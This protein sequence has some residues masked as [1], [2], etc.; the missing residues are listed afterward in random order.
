MPAKKPFY[1]TLNS[2]KTVLNF[3]DVDNIL[4]YG[5]FGN[6]LIG[7]SFGSLISKGSTLGYE[8]TINKLI[9]NGEKN[10]ILTSFQAVNNDG[11][12]ILIDFYMQLCRLGDQNYI[13]VIGFEHKEREINQLS[14]SKSK[15]LLNSIKKMDLI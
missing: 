6:V 1:A 9:A 11:F 3:S 10:G 13:S 5:E 8:K 14:L 15:M 12:I 4:G 2:K 7:H